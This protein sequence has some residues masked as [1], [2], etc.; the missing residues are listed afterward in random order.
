MS[1]SK[2]TE[3]PLSEKIKVIRDSGSLSQRRL[4]EKYAC[5]KTQ[6]QQILKRKA[7]IEAAFE[8]DLL[9]LDAKRIKGRSENPEHDTRVWQW[10]QRMRGMAIPISGPMIQQKALELAQEMQIEDFKASGGW[11]QR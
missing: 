2:R 11:L 6:I 8:S 9:N 1:N 10:F 5:G 3:L 7:E 4:A